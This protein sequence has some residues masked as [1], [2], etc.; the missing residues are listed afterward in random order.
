MFLMQVASQAKRNEVAE[1]RKG[2]VAT[3]RGWLSSMRGRAL[4]FTKKLLS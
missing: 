4:S 1:R 2:A 3:V